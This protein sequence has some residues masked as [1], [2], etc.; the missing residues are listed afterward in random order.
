MSNPAISISLNIHNSTGTDVLLN[1]DLKF[2]L[3]NPD[4][5]GNYFNWEGP[6]TGTDHI[7]FSSSPVSFAAGETK[8][9]HNVRW[10]EPETGWGLGGKSPANAE[11]LAAAERP[12]NVLVYV[13]EPDGTA[14]SEIVMCDN[15]DSN[16]V[17][18][19]GGI[20]DIV[21]SSVGDYT[22]SPYDPGGGDDPGGGGGG[23]SDVPSGDPVNPPSSAAV[24]TYNIKAF[25]WQEAKE[26]SLCAM[27]LA[28]YKGK[29]TITNTD[30]T[31]F[32][33]VGICVVKSTNTCILMVDSIGYVFDF[34]GNPVSPNAAKY[35]LKLA[36][37]VEKVKTGGNA[38]QSSV[39][40][41]T[42]RS[43]GGSV[44]TKTSIGNTTV[45]IDGLTPRDEFAVQALRELLHYDRQKDPSSLSD[46]EM[47][48]YCNMAYRWAAN[49][50]N[51]SA[52]TRAIYKDNTATTNLKEAAVG[53]LTN[54]TEKLLNNIMVAL[55][56]TDAKITLNNKSQDAECVT[57]PETNVLLNRIANALDVI[58]SKMSSGSSSGSGGSGG[59][60]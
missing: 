9:F 15:M 52:K 45:M 10:V 47:S 34:K 40:N 23:G 17:F 26:G 21:L 2:T 35:V 13:L 60:A 20:Y 28:T 49:M 48:F 58:A 56:K 37:I 36:T 59:G 3:G 41:V 14:N 46:N 16:I 31:N 25:D 38:I 1:G 30:T 7:F 6:Y 54:N 51:E 55:K 22:P 32:G 53:E 27:V 42:T 24:T 44:S 4:R 57:I 33:G 43:T 19:E 12:R 29:S 18:T 8:T 39:I 11:Q 5:N 50:M